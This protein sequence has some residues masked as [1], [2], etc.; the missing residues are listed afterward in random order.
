MPH[1]ITVRF[2]FHNGDIHAVV[3]TPLPPAQWR[4]VPSMDV[5]TVESLRLSHAHGPDVMPLLTTLGP[6]ARK[7]VSALR[8]AVASAAKTD[9]AQARA[10]RKHEMLGSSAGCTLA[11]LAARGDEPRIGI[12]YITTMQERADV[13]SLMREGLVETY[14][15]VE[16]TRIRVTPAGRAAL[17]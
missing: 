15:D 3:S 9:L 4:A 16:V 13:L 5:T 12:D 14:V 8:A 6:I 1:L 7:L 11:Q 17:R 2:P 10:A